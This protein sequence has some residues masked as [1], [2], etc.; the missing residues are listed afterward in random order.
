MKFLTRDIDRGLF[1]CFQA[2]RCLGVFIKLTA[3]FNLYSGERFLELSAQGSGTTING[4]EQELAFSP[5]TNLT[6]V[7]AAEWMSTDVD[8]R[9]PSFLEFLLPQQG[10]A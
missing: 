9:S 8:A 1:T 5:L 4:D 6:N 10:Q 7:P 2:V 3:S